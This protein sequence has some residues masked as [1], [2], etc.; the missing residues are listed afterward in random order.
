MTMRRGEEGIY[1]LI[2]KEEIDS[3]CARK[4]EGTFLDIADIIIIK[5]IKYAWCALEERSILHTL[6]T[7]TSA[8]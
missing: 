1:R 6:K 5:E 4:R 7:S 8:L 2:E 3:M